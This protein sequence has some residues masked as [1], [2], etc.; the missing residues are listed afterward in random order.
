MV[1]VMGHS[2]LPWLLCRGGE[3]TEVKCGFDDHEFY[4]Y[5]YFCLWNS[6]FS[7][8]PRSSSGSIVCRRHCPEHFAHPSLLVPTRCGGI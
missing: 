2:L 3:Q 5:I 7:P 1:L 6:E 8:F 4:I